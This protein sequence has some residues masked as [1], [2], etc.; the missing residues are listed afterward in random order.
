M[1]LQYH[2]SSDLRRIRTDKLSLSQEKMAEKLDISTRQYGN[3]E[4]GRA[5]PS[6]KIFLRL[7]YLMELNTEDYR[8]EILRELPENQ[9][10]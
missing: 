10:E 6:L 7:V 4:N 2:L 8:E 3:L 9:T 1:S 5:L